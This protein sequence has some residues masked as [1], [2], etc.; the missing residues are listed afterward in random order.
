VLFLAPIV[1][2]GDGVPAVGTLGTRSPAGAL[3]LRGLR[4]DWAGD[5]LV[6]ETSLPFSPVAL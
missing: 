3:R 6:L 2:G 4:T 5:D 1:I